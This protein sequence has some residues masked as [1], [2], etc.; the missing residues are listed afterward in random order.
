MRDRELVRGRREPLEKPAGLFW[1]QLALG[2][3][4]ALI[5]SGALPHFEHQRAQDEE[6]GW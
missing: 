6:Q 1:R 2:D 4:T 5:L 3:V